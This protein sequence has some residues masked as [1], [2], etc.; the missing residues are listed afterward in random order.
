MVSVL[1]FAPPTF[2]FSRGVVSWFRASL[3]QGTAQRSLSGSKTHPTACCCMAVRGDIPTRCVRLF[4]CGV[5][6]LALTFDS[7]CESPLR[8]PVFLVESMPLYF[9]LVF[10]PS[11]AH[12]FCSSYHGEVE[13]CSCD[14]ST[15]THPLR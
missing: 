5:A 15:S 10:Y 13:S 6:D 2:P 1:Y 7:W 14:N 11:R 8:T 12:G 9:F 3:P 4:Q